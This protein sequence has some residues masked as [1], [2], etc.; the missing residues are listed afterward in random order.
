MSISSSNMIMISHL[1]CGILDH[2]E[3]RKYVEETGPFGKSRRGR[4]RTKHTTTAKK[5]DPHIAYFG[6]ALKF[7]M[8]KA[9]GGDRASPKAS[10][11]RSTSQTNIY[12]STPPG[13]LTGP[14]TNTAPVGSV[15]VVQLQKE[16]T[17]VM[18]YGYRSSQQHSAIQRYETISRG[19]VCEGY[20]REPPD[21]FRRFRTVSSYPVSRALT[22]EERIKANTFA[23]GSCWI[24]VTFDS[25]QSADRAVDA[26]PQG[27]NGYQVFAELYRGLPPHRDEP[28]LATLEEP[29]PGGASRTRPRSGS[30]QGPSN[31]VPASSMSTTGNG[32][33]VASTL[34][35]SFTTFSTPGAGESP[36]SLSSSTASSATVTGYAAPG[37]S[38]NTSYRGSNMAETTPAAPEVCNLIPSARKIKLRPAE[39]AVLPRRTTF[40]R[41]TSY[42]P[43]I[44]FLREPKFVEQIPRLED[45]RFDYAGA[46]L[47]WRCCFWLDRVLGTDLCGLRD[48]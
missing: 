14:D 10:R 1:T 29:S 42:L 27:I 37:A 17:E 26:S 16:P 43:M 34:P 47:Y 6:E 39:E 38:L 35:R 25:S 8:G 48:E 21:G 24:K 45:G 40:E 7:D 13:G 33:R 44:S 18:L 30:A 12:P 9:A 15:P 32:S 5:E 20:A 23:G 2:S 36:S 11:S 28:I 4:S 3:R 22:A 31:L 19:Y 41:V 46:S